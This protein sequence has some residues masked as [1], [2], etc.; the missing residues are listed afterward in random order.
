MHGSSLQFSG[1][2]IHRHQAR[3]QT[4]LW[5]GSNRSNFR[6]FYDYAWIILRSR[7]IWPFWGGGHSDPP[8]RPPGYGPGHLFIARFNIHENYI[9]WSTEH[10]S[11]CW[12]TM[13]FL[14]KV[15][16][17]HICKMRNLVKLPLLLQQTG[18]RYVLWTILIHGIRQI[19]YK[20][21]YTVLS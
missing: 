1:Y 6:T 8:D 15:V 5:G 10:I 13:Q 21:H 17:P 20:I 2:K 16:A 12:Q 9:L 11:S 7:W 19:K 18:S 14:S 4:F 3:S